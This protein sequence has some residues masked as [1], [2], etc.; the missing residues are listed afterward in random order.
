[1]EFCFFKQKTAYEM[2]ISDWSSD[3]C[4][5][6]LYTGAAGWMYRAG[7]EGI[8][9][10]RREGSFLVVD[11]CIPSAWPGFEATVKV[12][13]THYDIRV[14]APSHCHRD[15]SPAVL[16]GLLIQRTEGRSEEHTSELQSL[17]R[18]SY[19]VFFL[20]KNTTTP[21]K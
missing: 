10:I 11:P 1:M 21:I 19:A 6:D 18:I 13:S 7:V 16:D 20:T 9:G 17:M 8:L 14:E 3:V 15:A 4:S 5:S 12:G 2:R